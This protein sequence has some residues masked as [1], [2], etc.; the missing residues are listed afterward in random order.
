M[1]V[2][3]KHILMGYCANKSQR[4]VKWREMQ[5]LSPFDPSTSSSFFHSANNL[6]NF[7]D[8]VKSKLHT[9]KWVKVNKHV[10]TDALLHKR[11]IVTNEERE[12]NKKNR[13]PKHWASKGK[14]LSSKSARVAMANGEKKTMWI[15]RTIWWKSSSKHS[16]ARRSVGKI[17]WNSHTY[18]FL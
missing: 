7:I 11:A 4:G 1:V 2:T 15:P 6:R 12:I 16:L 8:E 18:T 17:R 13:I 9:S 3:R 10:H 5:E 14:K